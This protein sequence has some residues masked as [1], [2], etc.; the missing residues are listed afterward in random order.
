MA[1]PLDERRP[2]APDCV[3]GFPENRLQAA[4]LAEILGLDCTMVE[5][6]CFP[7]CETRVRVP[8][9]ARF[10]LVLRSLDHPNA[11]LVELLL[12]AGALRDGGAQSILLAA[13][14]LGYMR[15]DIA[16][17]R[18][19][20]VSQ[21]IIGRVLAAHFDAFLSVDP[22][23]HRT[24]A[25]RDVFTG[26]PALAISAAP[27]IAA[28]VRRK[29]Y[30]VDTLVIGPDAESRPWV[31]AV[32]KP[33]GL[34]WATALKRRSGDRDV[35]I[36]LPK[37]LAVRGRPVLLVDDLI[38]TGGTIARIAGLLKAAGAA[39]IDAYVTHALFSPEDHRMMTAAGVRRI[40]SCD[41]VLHP[42]NAVD[43]IP[44]IARDLQA[45]HSP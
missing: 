20:A 13:P 3:Y 23:L 34:S 44:D 38:S 6:H 19:E 10:P 29:D 33:L 17:S 30:S 12:T 4:R 41:T 21:R 36:S 2:P 11:K 42:T 32:A 22:H 28:A 40:A 27:A 26:A 8:A 7:D 35:D 45:W 1:T 5:L 9:A 31:T 43:I 24:P 37:N 18:G 39:A 15:Q 25:L 14:Y 16:F